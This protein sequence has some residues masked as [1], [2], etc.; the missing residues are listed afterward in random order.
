MKI[1]DLGRMKYGEAY[2][3]Q[4]DAFDRHVEA[5]RNKTECPEDII[6][7]VEHD[8]VYTMGFHADS[9]NLLVSEEILIEQGAELF[10]IERGGDVT[11]HGPGQIVL[12]PILD[13]ER[14]HLTVK[15][16]VHILEESVIRTVGEYGITATRLDNAPGVWISDTKG[17]RKICA[18]GIKCS[19]HITM[20]GLALNVTTDLTR[21]S[22]INPCG[23]T[24]KGVTSLAAEL[25]YNAPQQNKDNSNI[26]FSDTNPS[27]AFY[28][29]LQRLVQNLVLLLNKHL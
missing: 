7:C 11:Y 28:D 21:F 16:Y 9:R 2:R 13:L 25:R 12:Y 6:F 20:H 29:I 26:N 4:R 27:S 3:L 24:T 8:P 17:D 23:F 15:E 5:K 18:L 22:A 10:R 1:I 14:L 19:R